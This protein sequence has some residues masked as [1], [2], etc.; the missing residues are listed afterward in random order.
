MYTPWIDAG[1]T[2]SAEAAARMIQ[3][4]ASRSGP[5]LKTAEATRRSIV[6]LRS[7]IDIE[8]VH[9]TARANLHDAIKGGHQFLD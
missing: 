9:R 2:P 7:G 5:S 1:Q 4:A 3:R 6:P 8:D